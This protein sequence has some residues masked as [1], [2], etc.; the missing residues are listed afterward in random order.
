MVLS[1]FVY[2]GMVK[3]YLL[4]QVES[5]NTYLDSKPSTGLQ[6]GGF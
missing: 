6:T 2:T 4:N 1:K 5:I 3:E